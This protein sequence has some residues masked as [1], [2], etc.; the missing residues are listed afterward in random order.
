M[1]GDLD[2]RYKACLGSREGCCGGGCQTL[3]C[4]LDI[5]VLYSKPLHITARQYGEVVLPVAASGQ[6]PGALARKWSRCKLAC[7]QAGRVWRAFCRHSTNFIACWCDRGTILIG[8]TNLS[9]VTNLL[10]GTGAVSRYKL[11]R[12]QLFVR[13]QDFNCVHLRVSECKL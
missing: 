1:S 7:R 9:P 11:S 4:V 8:A 5:M 2:E 10:A 12:R 6:C 13:V 3:A